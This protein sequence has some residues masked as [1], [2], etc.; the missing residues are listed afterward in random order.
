MEQILSETSQVRPAH[1]F[2][3]ENLKEYMNSHVEEFT[4][5]LEIRQFTHGQSNPTFILDDGHRKYVLRKKP[6]GKLLPS[7]HQVE[8]E[9]RIISAL[10]D[11]DVPVPQTYALCTDD[12]VIGTAFYIMELVE[13]RIFRDA[14][15]SQASGSK[16]RA[17]IFDAMNDTLAR[18]H[19]VDWQALGLADYGKPGNYM[20]RQVA[21]WSKQYQASE[22]DEIKSM[23]A[24]MEWLPR[25]LPEDTSPTIVHG[26]YRLENLIIHPTEPRV[27]AVLDWEISTLGHPLA[28]LAYT[29]MNYRIPSMEGEAIGL[30][31]LDL[32]A[33]GIPSEEAFV[34]TYCRRT[35]REIPEDWPFFIAFSLFRLAAIAQGVYKRGLDGIASSE[36]ALAVGAYVKVLA[37]IAWHQ[38]LGR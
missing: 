14:R 15:A 28:D 8:R 5:E 35:G 32:E 3:L 17:A 9:Y 34:E 20:G 25:H 29:C 31:G 13:G 38:V 33:L 11:T 36:T 30:A 7:A 16:E 21:R 24:L 4:G 10:Y 27:V 1:R 22:T 12:G 23:D 26:D 2:D 19:K 6:P 18:I 37:D